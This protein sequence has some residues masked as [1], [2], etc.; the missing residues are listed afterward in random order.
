MELG[1]VRWKL[2]TE[3][4]EIFN[5]PHDSLGTSGLGSPADG[6]RRI[7]APIVLCVG[8]VPKQSKMAIEAEIE[9]SF[10]Y[11]L[12]SKLCRVPLGKIDMRGFLMHDN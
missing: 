3:G 2:Q 12:N 8:S 11:Y 1:N 6:N 4:A 10:V 7:V 9:N 5:S